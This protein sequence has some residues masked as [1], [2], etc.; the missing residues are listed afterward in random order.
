M[1]TL[2]KT[3]IV[4]LALAVIVGCLATHLAASAT[5]AAGPPVVSAAMSDSTPVTS[6]VCTL[7]NPYCNYPYYQT[8]VCTGSY[9]YSQTYYG[10]PYNWQP[11]SNSYWL[12]CAYPNGTGAWYRWGTQPF[13]MYCS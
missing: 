4:Q 2:R 10:W 13:G 8:P 12:W 5:R 7:A 9:C 3:L 6:Q 1:V 11:Y